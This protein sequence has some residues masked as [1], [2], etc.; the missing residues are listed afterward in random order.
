LIR[1]AARTREAEQPAFRS[2]FLAMRTALMFKHL[3]QVQE[4]EPLPVPAIM[5]KRLSQ[6]ASREE[7]PVTAIVFTRP[8]KDSRPSC[9]HSQS[10]PSCSNG[11]PMLQEMINHPPMPHVHTAHPCPSLPPT[12]PVD[13]WGRRISPTDG[14]AWDRIA[15]GPLFAPEQGSSGVTPSPLR[16]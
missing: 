9:S 6:E 14:G 7:A 1:A 10:L 4:Q 16:C 11:S 15:N 12:K 3:G 5:F 8:V 2:G 13:S